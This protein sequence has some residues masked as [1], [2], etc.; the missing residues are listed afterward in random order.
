HGNE[1]ALIT[2]LAGHLLPEVWVSTDLPISADRA[3]SADRS[4]P[5]DRVGPLQTGRTPVTGSGRVAQ[6]V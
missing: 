2:G 1:K 5:G 3:I 6:A 4:D